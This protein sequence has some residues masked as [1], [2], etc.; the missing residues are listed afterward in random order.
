LDAPGDI[1]K[2][3]E[4]SKT[5]LAWFFDKTNRR[6]FRH[7]LMAAAVGI[8]LVSLTPIGNLSYDVSC[9]AKPD[10]IITNLVLV[11]INE[12]TLETLPSVRGN[13]SRMY[14][15]QLLNRLTQERARLVFYDIV[16]DQPDQA[17]AIDRSLVQAVRNQGS[18]ILVGTCQDSIEQGVVR[19]TSLYPPIRPLL[20]A[21]KG[22]GHAELFGDDIRHISVDYDFV[23]YAVWVAATNLEPEGLRDENPNRNRWLNYYS[24]PDKS[25]FSYCSLQDALSKNIPP[26]F[27][28]N[29]I[30]FVGQ[31]F[32]SDDIGRRRDTFA[33]PFS[34]F[35]AAP[36]PGV[37]IHATALLNLLRNDWFRQ[38]PLGCQ[39][40]GAVIWAIVSVGTLYA[41]SRKPWLVLVFA[42]VFGAALLCV[43]SLYVQWH[44]HWWWTW[45]GPAFGQTAVALFLVLNAPKPDRYIAFI[46]YRTEEDGAAAL[47]IAWSL[48][49]Q[50]YKAFIDVKSLNMGRFDEQLYRE[51]ESAKV[52]ILILSPN[53]LARCVNEN[54]WV[55]KELDHALA[56][57]KI[58]IPVMKNGF[59]F[60]AKEGIP[61]LPQ[62]AALKNY[63]G[64]PYSH[65]DFEGFMR[66]LVE[67]LKD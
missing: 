16:F 54:D 53:S 18:V 64:L 43:F 52:F 44:F 17:P 2:F 8:L 62:I 48:S 45:M 34:R 27:F 7:I 22:W 55:K 13:L 37:E 9:E 33:T 60:D 40:I 41:L 66:R 39:W 29:K 59:N 35:G 6:L 32:P 28:T 56:N 38:V 14:H 26:G 1:L 15:T 57:Q 63:H 19:V 24:R 3:I 65:S 46:S 20:E 4:M 23:H 21:A 50:G 67:L 5:P 36:I 11:Y 31:N 47:L 49:E 51:I 25:A 58:I 42:A 61:D 12:G 10:T 30:V